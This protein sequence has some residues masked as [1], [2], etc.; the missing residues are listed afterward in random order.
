MSPSTVISLQTARICEQSAAVLKKPSKS[1]RLR[2][3]AGATGSRARRRNVINDE[4]HV[5]EQE[6]H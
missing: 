3:P 1:I 4:V 5:Q 6:E 2:T